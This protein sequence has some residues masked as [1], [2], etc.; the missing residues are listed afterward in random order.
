[1]GDTKESKVAENAVEGLYQLLKT[2]F[3]KAHEKV[4][5]NEMPCQTD[6]QAIATMAFGYAKGIE[7]CGMVCP[8]IISINLSCGRADRFLKGC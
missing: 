7:I 4:M 3:P 6:M 8:P 5:N 2:N 1:M